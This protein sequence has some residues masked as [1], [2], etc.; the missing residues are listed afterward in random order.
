MKKFGRLFGGGSKDDLQRVSDCWA[1]L[2]EHHADRPSWLNSPTIGRHVNRLI[3]GDERFSWF[4]WF[5]MKYL[6][7]SQWGGRGL[8]LGCNHG[9]FERQIVKRGICSAMDGY[10][11]SQRSIDIARKA[12][13]E[14]GL[15]LHYG[16]ADVN[17]LELPR[18]RYDLVVAAAAVHHFERLEAV[19]TR[20][21][22]AL[23]PR[24]FF[25]FNEYVG[26]ARFQWTDAQLRAINR[27][28]DALPPELRRLP[29]GS[30][31]PPVAKADLAA[32]IREDPSESVRSDEIVPLAHEH[33]D[34]VE[35]RDYGGTIL[36]MFFHQILANFDETRPEHVALIRMVCAAEQAL[37]EEGILPSDFTVLVCRRRDAAP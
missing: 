7:E 19:F 32:L 3:G 5:Q 25:V 35:Q 24:G 11:V 1:D 13:A 20:V 33:F 6:P 23:T 21:H 16:V 29:D 2:A 18:N 22:E 36:H 31:A 14:E 27:L 9:L 34:V 8:S 28:R 37:I 30:V 4:D 12:A 15:D 10:D 17:A 26:P